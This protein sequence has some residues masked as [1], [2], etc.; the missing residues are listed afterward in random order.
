MHMI[1]NKGVSQIRQISSLSEGNGW[2]K[3]GGSD[4]E[5]GDHRL[6][7]KMGGYDSEIAGLDKELGGG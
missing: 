4:R 3:Q 5:M 6:R 7:R 2:L 1:S